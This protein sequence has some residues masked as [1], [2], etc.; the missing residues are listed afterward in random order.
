M[1]AWMDRLL[2]WCPV[3]RMAVGGYC[4]YSY[5]QERSYQPSRFGSCGHNVDIGPGVFIRS[6]ENMKIGDGVFIGSN[7]T[8]D[9][10]GGFQLGNCCALAANT[11]VLTLDHHFRD[12][13]SIP[14]GEARMIKPVKIEDYVWV[15][16]N[17]SILP[18]VTLG[19]GAIVGLGTV[20]P[21]DVPPLAIIVGN[22]GKIVGY[23][24]RDSFEALKKSG[25]I[26]AASARCTRLWV[27]QEM[28]RK[29]PELLRDAGYDISNGREYFEFPGRK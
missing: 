6:P 16:M 15:G 5:L 14:W 13:E 4:Y 26:R 17:A 27:P 21:K 24:D 25:A 23:R 28:R 8:I 1:K 20:V 9:A 22:P 18:G 7:C 12:A 11:T 2:S 10:I 3:Y 29:Y 19:E